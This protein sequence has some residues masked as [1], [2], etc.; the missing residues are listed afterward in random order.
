MENAPCGLNQFQENH[1]KL[2]APYV[3]LW[4]MIM[5]RQQQ[6]TPE[7]HTGQTKAIS[8]VMITKSSEDEVTVAELTSAH[9]GVRHG[10]SYLSTDCEKKVRRMFTL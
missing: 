4:W 3:L 1:F 2:A 6:Q 8:P 7:V 10:L 9:H 5:L